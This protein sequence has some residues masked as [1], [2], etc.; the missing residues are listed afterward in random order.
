MKMLTLSKESSMDSKAEIKSVLHRYIVE[1]ED[2]ELLK[3]AK[4]YFRSLLK[5]RRKIIG[6]K[7]DGYPLDI[8]AYK[9]EIDEARQQVK[10]GKT[11]SQ[12]QIEKAS[13]NW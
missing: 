6:Y 9:K 7:S 4:E 2:L 8:E 5:N 10:E 11:I 12:E 3:Q 13:E 1:T